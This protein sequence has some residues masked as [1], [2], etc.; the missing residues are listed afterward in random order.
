M[1]IS[2]TQLNLIETTLN[3]QSEII[4]K[5]QQQIKQICQCKEIEIKTDLIKS[6]FFPD[7][8]RYFKKC[9]CCDKETDITK[10]EYL[11]FN[12]EAMNGALEEEKQSNIMAKKLA[13]FE[14]ARRSR[15]SK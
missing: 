7:D 3:N 12:I 2:K 4:N 11:K 15:I 9:K 1:F 13:K 8:T 5:L 6:F 10:E 14:N